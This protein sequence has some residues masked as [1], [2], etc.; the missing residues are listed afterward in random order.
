[1]GSTSPSVRY[2]ALSG[3]VFAHERRISISQVRWTS[4]VGV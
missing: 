4:C 1:M 3:L 2:W